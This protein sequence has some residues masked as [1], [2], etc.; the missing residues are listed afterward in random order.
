MQ[1]LK[2]SRAGGRGVPPCTGQ[3]EAQHLAEVGG[4]QRIGGLKMY[5]GNCMLHMKGTMVPGESGGHVTLEE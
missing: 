1:R 2:N 5:L 3:Y 4:I